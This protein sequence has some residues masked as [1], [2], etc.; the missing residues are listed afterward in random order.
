MI[1]TAY[2]GRLEGRIFLSFG[3]Q[4]ERLTRSARTLPSETM[5]GRGD[6]GSWRRTP[7]NHA[8]PLPPTSHHRLTVLGLPGFLPS[9]RCALR[10]SMSIAI[11]S[12][13]P[14]PGSQLSLRREG[15]WPRKPGQH[16]PRTRQ[17]PNHSLPQQGI[18]ADFTITPS[19][20]MGYANLLSP[21]SPDTAHQQQS[22]NSGCAQLD[23]Q[24]DADPGLRRCDRHVWPDS[25]G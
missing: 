9:A 23:C 10:S 1:P 13:A 15:A 16:R 25:R 4:S 11:M 2:G 17:N 20:S 3:P 21:L 24:I 14:G 22:F 12:S 8:M 5:A 7:P 19:C 18:S 6:L